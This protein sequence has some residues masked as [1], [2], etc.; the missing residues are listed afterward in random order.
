[1]ERANL[2]GVE[3]DD[4]TDLVAVIR[5]VRSHMGQATGDQNPD[6]KN[7]KRGI[8]HCF[9]NF[10]FYFPEEGERGVQFSIAH[11]FINK[12]TQRSE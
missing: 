4:V 10:F 12:M 5:G 3:R 11:G 6:D 8:A 2:V 9:W 1:M 7:S